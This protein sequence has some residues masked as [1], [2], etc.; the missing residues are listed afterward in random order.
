M[1]S[2]QRKLLTLVG[3]L[4]AGMIFGGPACL[5]KDYWYDFAA[6]GRT[7]VLQAFANAV[8]GTIT[9]TLFPTAGN[10]NTN[11]NSSGA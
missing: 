10:D 7:S 5:P 9:G 3:V 8:F 1:K 6:N 4:G 11:S 2:R